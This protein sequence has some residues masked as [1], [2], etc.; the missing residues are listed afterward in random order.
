[1]EDAKS[2]QIS[3]TETNSIQINSDTRF[4]VEMINFAWVSKLE[5][6]LSTSFIVSDFHNRKSKTI[7]QGI[8]LFN[9]RKFKNLPST[10]GLV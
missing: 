8:Q 1:M 3:Q 7:M 10:G 9:Q 6:L 5:F 4:C 2:Q